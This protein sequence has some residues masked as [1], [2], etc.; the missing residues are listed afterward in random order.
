[1]AK[2]KR[3]STR[4]LHAAAQ[5]VAARNGATQWPNGRVA[6]FTAKHTYSIQQG[7]QQRLHCNAQHAPAIAAS[8]PQAVKAYWPAATVA[9]RKYAIHAPTNAAQRAAVRLAL[10]PVQKGAGAVTIG[11]S[12][13]IGGQPWHYCRRTGTFSAKAAGVLPAVGALTAAQVRRNYGAAMANKILQLG[14]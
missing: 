8:T 9:S 12:A 3:T 11:Y 6:A 13:V 2:H 4:T 1:M 14:A 7:T 10:M 5:V